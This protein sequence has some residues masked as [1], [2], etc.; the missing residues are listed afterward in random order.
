MNL[1]G[2]K[3]QYGNNVNSKLRDISCNR[4]EALEK[5]KNR[6]KEN[7]SNVRVLFVN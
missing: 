1:Q 4:I 7:K 2:G 6:P 5:K 3:S